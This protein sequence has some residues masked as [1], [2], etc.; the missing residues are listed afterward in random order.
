MPRDAVD[1]YNGIAWFYDR[2]WRGLCT[3]FLPV[4]DR[5]VLS[6]LGRG[7]R[8]L[9]LCCGTGHLAAALCRRGYDV[10]GVDASGDMLR[11]ARRNAP[12][13]RF[14]LGDIRSFHLPERFDA[15]VSTG[16]SLNHLLTPGGLTRSLRGALRLLRPGGRMVFDV[17]TREAYM[18]EWRKSSTVAEPDNLIFV[19]GQYD[20]RTRIG[21]TEITAFRRQNG[22]QRLDI[23]LHQRSYLRREMRAALTESG[24]TGIRIQRADSLGLRGRLSVGRVFVTARRPS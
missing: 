2:Y 17:N 4:L 16:D 12:A 19:R 14:L 24:F 10:T 18:R 22:W 20:A 1:G 7:S 13:A 11:F 23:T 3:R 9:D 8:I 5:L 15:I 6:G 21:T